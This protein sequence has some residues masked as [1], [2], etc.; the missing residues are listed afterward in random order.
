MTSTLTAGDRAVAP[1][2]PVAPAG[3]TTVDVERRDGRLAADLRR[4]ALAPYPLDDDGRTLRVALVATGALLLGGDHVG[5]RV[6]VGAGVVLELVETSGTVAYDGR[7][8]SA[9]WEV[10]VEVEAGGVL[11]WDAQPFVVA[12]GADVHRTTSVRL[13]AG[14]VACLHETV[15]LGRTGEH[16]GRLLTS[17]RV[18]DPTGP[19]LHEELRLD[20]ARPEP[21]VLGDHRVLDSVV[22]VG[23]RPAA[24]PEPG[25]AV[26]VLQLEEPGAVARRAGTEVHRV[27][28]TDVAAAWSR[29][30][31]RET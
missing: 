26:T 1:V 21:G 11:V 27:V 13:G 25:D 17:L 29:D 24:A 18:D 8:E 12:T 30:G 10:D 7:G 5:I 15:V 22:L 14:A 4:G 3:W 31:C 9:R 28:L 16:G 19:V 23:R 20:G 6:R 2:A